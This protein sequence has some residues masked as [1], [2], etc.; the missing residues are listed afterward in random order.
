MLSDCVINAK[1]A[2]F[3]LAKVMG[4]DEIVKTFIMWWG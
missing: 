1:M 4:Q 3:G 2:D